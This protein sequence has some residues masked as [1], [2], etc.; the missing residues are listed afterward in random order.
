M[1]DVVPWHIGL[2]AVSNF[3]AHPVEDGVKVC[4]LCFPLQHVNKSLNKPAASCSVSPAVEARN[5][6][7]NNQKVGV[8]G[9]PAKKVEKFDG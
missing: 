4:G 8:T 5:G 7:I 6:G 9:N 2:E 1:H 3:P